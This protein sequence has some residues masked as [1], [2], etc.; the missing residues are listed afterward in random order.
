[1][2][3]MENIMISVLGALS[4]TLLSVP[5]IWYF[6]KNPIKVTGD[7]REAYENFG[8]EPIFYFSTEPVIFYSQTIVVLCIALVLSI[9]P[10]F[11]IGRLEPVLA[12]RG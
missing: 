6:Y 1:M 11:K 7:L 8:F 3:I 2:V 9:Y 4:G 5:L 10:F 12:M